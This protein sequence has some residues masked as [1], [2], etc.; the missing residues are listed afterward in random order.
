MTFT[1][2]SGHRQA[3]MGEEVSHECRMALQ[4][5][6]AAAGVGFELGERGRHGVGHASLDDGVRLFLWIQLGRVGRQGGRGVVATMGGE[7]GLDLVRRVGGAAIP[8]DEQGMPEHVAKVAERPAGRRS[9]HTAAHVP[10]REA[11]RRRH[12]DHTRDLPPLAHAAQHRGPALGSPGRRYPGPKRVTRFVHAGNR[13]P[14]AP[15]FFFNAGQSRR[16]QAR[17]TTSS[18]SFAC[19]AGRCGVKPWALSGRS[20]Y[21]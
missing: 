7:K 17:T 3:G 11:A 1:L 21:R 18:R 8:D 5:A 14:F 16:S 4:V 9:F 15:S 12:R 13:P 2:M 19:T 6:N 10:R 20:R